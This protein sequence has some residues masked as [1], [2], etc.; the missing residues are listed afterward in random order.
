MNKKENT[1]KGL[2]WRPLSMMAV[3]FTILAA[4]TWETSY[5]DVVA[6]G[7]ARAWNLRETV[8]AFPTDIRVSE[9]NSLAPEADIL[10]RGDPPGDRR[11]QVMK[12]FQNAVTRAA[13]PM[14]G[15]RPVKISIQVLRFHGV[16]ERTRQSTVANIGVHSITFRAQVID[17]RTG[18]ALTPVDTIRADLPA[19][20]GDE[21][22]LA[23]S[24]GQTQK[25][26]VTNHLTAVLS[27]WLGLGPDVRRTFERTGR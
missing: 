6:P 4:C 18:M 19:L 5:K 25:V 21:A 10:W 23:E 8:I 17:A 3:V 13:R 24:R 20:T 22:V 15:S 9:E 14:Q 2:N 1:F 7:S 26:R 27:G 11:Q 16:T 12:I